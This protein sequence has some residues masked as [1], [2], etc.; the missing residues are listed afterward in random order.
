MEKEHGL[1][2]LVSLVMESGD[3]MPSF[4]KQNIYAIIIAFTRWCESK[5]YDSTKAESF[6]KFLLSTRVPVMYEDYT[7]WLAEDTVEWLEE[8]L[9][10]KMYLLEYGGGNSTIWFAKRVKHICCWENH[11]EWYKMIKVWAEREDLDNL[12]LLYK[13]EDVPHY[14]YD[15]VFVDND[16]FY[17]DE[18]GERGNI[19]RAMKIKEAFNYIKKDGIFGLDDDTENDNIARKVL[20]ENGWFCSKRLGAE[21]DHLTGFYKYGN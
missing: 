20:N 18:R 4:H 6:D 19:H 2:R 12:T 1:E 16:A 10:D 17:K 21:G 9:T 11:P 13:G 3:L 8:I 5:G 15:F 14:A 7:P